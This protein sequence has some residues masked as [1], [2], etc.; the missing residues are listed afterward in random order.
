MR[1]V[2]LI[3]ARNERT[4]LEIVVP[5]LARQ[6]VE[7]VLIDNGSTDGGLDVMTPARHPNL[8]EVHHLPYDGHFDLG[9][10]LRFKQT[11]AGEIAT[12]WLIHQDADEILQ[13]RHGWGGLRA[14]IEHADAAGCNVVNF[15]ELVM[16]PLDPGVDDI[17]ANNRLAYLFK[18]N[19]APRLMRAWKAD[20]PVTNA[21][22]G[23]HK[24]D[25]P[26]L[27]L[28]PEFQVLKHF[29]VRSQAHAIEK[30]LGRRFAR[31]DTERGWH[32]NRL[33]LTREDLRL[34]A[35]GERDSLTTLASPKVLPEPWPAPEP[36][37]FWQWRRSAEA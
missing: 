35:P 18:K 31:S 13:S 36:L 3:A 16:L 11:L 23:G 34:P 7:V 22:K 25:R 10:Q 24:V 15:E 12:D 37:H 19:P 14:A 32:G 5:Y 33:N 20:R 8:I 1:I 9:R 29:I 28:F 26:D 17:F 27:K 4:Y 21:H 6:G 30:Y 2:A